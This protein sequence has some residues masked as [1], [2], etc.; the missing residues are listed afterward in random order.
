MPYCI[1]KLYTDISSAV[2]NNN[3]EVLDKILATAN[4]DINSYDSSGHTILTKIASLITISEQMKPAFNRFLSDKNSDINLFD[5]ING[6]TAL[7]FAVQNGNVNAVE[8][9]LKH[10]KIAINHKSLN[11]NT[12]LIWLAQVPAQFFTDKHNKILNLLLSTPGINPNLTD[13]LSDA[14]PLIYAIDNL[15]LRV[16]S[17]LLEHSE[18]N[19]NFKSERGQTALS[20]TLDYLL[21]YSN[22]IDF[23]TKILMML[24]SRKDLNLELHL[25]LKCKNKDSILSNMIIISICSMNYTKPI[26]DI[27]VESLFNMHMLDAGSML[28]KIGK[29]YEKHA[30]EHEVFFE[31]G[32]SYVT[33]ANAHEGKCLDNKLAKYNAVRFYRRAAELGSTDAR[34]KI[35]AMRYVQSSHVHAQESLYA[36]Y[37]TLG[38]GIPL[39]LKDVSQFNH[40]TKTPKGFISRVFK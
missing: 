24:L 38:R 10:P 14:P 15:N 1:E 28:Y 37:Q 22:N 6:S 26:R 29:I 8:A 32:K 21:E 34:T 39:P 17:S 27:I 13:N 5:R 36:Q 30:N 3:I 31:I 4:L 35:L 12:A 18:L 20:I 2:V 16:A 11:G 40:N 23:N 9:L 25:D 19:I 33:H 7:Q